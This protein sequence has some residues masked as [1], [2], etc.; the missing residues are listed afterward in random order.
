MAEA[1]RSIALEKLKG[2]NVSHRIV[3]LAK[4]HQHEVYSI[5]LA[6]EEEAFLLED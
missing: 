3:A 1:I 4:K 5:M 2:E 6:V